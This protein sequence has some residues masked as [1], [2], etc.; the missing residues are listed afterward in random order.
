L[1]TNPQSKE[2]DVIAVFCLAKD[3]PQVEQL[4]AGLDRTFFLMH[5]V[6]HIN[7]KA[8]VRRKSLYPPRDFLELPLFLLMLWR[9]QSPRRSFAAI[10]ALFHAGPSGRAGHFSERGC[11]A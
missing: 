6:A 2:G 10:F 4:D 7:R 5:S 11:L 8:H 9:V 1:A 3:V